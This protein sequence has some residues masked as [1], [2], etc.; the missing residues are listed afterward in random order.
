MKIIV[1]LSMV[2]VLIAV[3]CNKPSRQGHELTTN[4]LII[5]FKTTT[6]QSAIDSL[7]AEMGL[8]RVKDI[9]ELNIKVYKLA[10]GM[11]MEKAI[12]KCQKNPHVEYA[13]PDYQ[14][15]ALE[16]KKKH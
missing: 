3:G 1:V 4:Q 9:P 15:R 12:K 13:E 8:Q 6:S 16:G 14:V 2:I 11:N 5:K 7:T 10:P